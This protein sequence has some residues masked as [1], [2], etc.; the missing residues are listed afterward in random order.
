MLKEEQGQILPYIAFTIVIMLMFVSYA[1]ST[2]VVFLERKKVE[3]ALDAALLSASLASVREQRVPTRYQDSLRRICTEWEDYD[4]SY[5]D[6]NGQYVPDT[7]SYCVDWYHQVVERKSYNKNYIRVASNFE[8]V[9]N[10]YFN[11]NLSANSKQ[12]RIKSITIQLTYDDERYFLI[13]KELKWLNP[14]A[15]H[16]DGKPIVGKSYNPDWW[17]SQFGNSTN[18][19]GQPENFTMTQDLEERIVRFPRWVKITAI[20]EVEI[21]APLSS[22][23]GGSTITIRSQSEVVRELLELDQPEPHN[24]WWNT[25]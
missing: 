9:I 10:N 11:R 3:D 8:S 24:V 22:I 21:P 12:A 4:C 23:I 14:P 7:C 15:T 20:A 5:T 2:S 16:S 25:E 6:E 1:L 17:F 13:D 18:F 19:Q